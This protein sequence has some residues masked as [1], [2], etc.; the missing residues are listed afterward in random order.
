MKCYFKKGFLTLKQCNAP[1]MGNCSISGKPVCAAHSV[2]LPDDKIVALD[3]ISELPPELRKIVEEAIEETD[4]PNQGSSWAYQNRRSWYSQ[5][6]YTPFY[7]GTY[8]YYRYDDYDTRGFDRSEDS[9]GDIE[10]E[11][12]AAAYDQ[13]DDAGSLYDS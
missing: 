4:H 6:G 10:G 8:A 2:Q 1:A 3:R 11:E 5:Y 9:V 7:V 12:A 13:D